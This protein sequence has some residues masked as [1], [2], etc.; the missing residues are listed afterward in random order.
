MSLIQRSSAACPR[1]AARVLTSSLTPVG[2]GFGRAGVGATMLARPTALPGLLGV[3]SATGNRVSWVVQ[4]L[5][6]REVALGLGTVAGLRS[7]D[8]RTGR[9]WLAAGLL[10]D[11]VDAVALAAAVRGKRVSTAPGVA[12][13]G[14]ALTAVAVAAAELSRGR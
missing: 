7:G 10:C 2:L 8:P 13:V 1:F 11:A 12:V 14:V 3:D 4:M 5:G 9:T 6:A